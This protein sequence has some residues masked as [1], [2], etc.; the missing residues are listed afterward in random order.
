MKY[1]SN[2]TH[3]IFSN[4]RKK[5]IPP[6]TNDSINLWSISSSKSCSNKLLHINRKIKYDRKSHMPMTNLA[7]HVKIYSFSF[8]FP[9]AKYDGARKVGK[10]IPLFFN[11]FQPK[12]HAHLFFTFYAF[13][14]RGDSTWENSISCQ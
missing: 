2:Q 14:A 7:S 3:F 4:K 10:K 11:T 9:L 5:S 8:P 6:L 12:C 1:I 13:S